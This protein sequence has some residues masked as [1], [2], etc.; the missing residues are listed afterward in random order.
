M[1][2]VAPIRIVIADDHRMFRQGL[3][4][5]LQTEPGLEIVG[6][7]TDG[8]D[9]LELVEQLKPDV[10]LLDLTMPRL[11]GLDVL[12]HLGPA[13][14]VRTILLTAGMERDLIVQA[15]RL[16]ARGVVLKHVGAEVLIKS[17][18]AVHAGEYWVEREI[19]AEWARSAQ[20]GGDKALPAGLTPR[21]MQIIQEILC[22]STNRDIAD[23]LKISEE[24]VKRHLSNVYDKLGVS[25]RLELALYAVSHKLI[26][27]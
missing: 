23:K 3:R 25:N 1:P 19:L 17:I 13:P 9:A 10:L 26:P 6:E 12:R 8:K 5:L 14:P 18:A 15:L 2:S 7:A 16:G 20:P 22:G 21:E 11:S 27:G 4:R 24:T